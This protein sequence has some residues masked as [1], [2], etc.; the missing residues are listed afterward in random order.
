MQLV[1]VS[2][3]LNAPVHSFGRLS[4]MRSDFRGWYD[5]SDSTSAATFR[6]G[7]KDDAERDGSDSQMRDLLC[8]FAG[9][10]RTPKLDADGN[11]VRSE[12]RNKPVFIAY[13]SADRASAMSTLKLEQRDM[14]DIGES[15]LVSLVKVSDETV[16]LTENDDDENDD[17]ENDDENDDDENDA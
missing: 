5:S 7:G 3:V 10:P 1:P 8:A 15:K 11:I 9:I 4:T 2:E 16:T 14:A 6:L 13:T 17:D 12:K